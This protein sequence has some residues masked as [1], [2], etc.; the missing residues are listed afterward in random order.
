MFDSLKAKI[1]I[2]EIRNNLKTI[3]T[4]A[5]DPEVRSEFKELIV[6]LV[7]IGSDIGRVVGKAEAVERA[8]HRLGSRHSFHAG[9]CPVCGSDEVEMTTEYHT[10]RFECNLCGKHMDLTT[11]D[12]RKLNISTKE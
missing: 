12:C 7:A 9:I 8:A 3:T 2:S 11:M 10:P 4:I 6:E 1:A 5:K